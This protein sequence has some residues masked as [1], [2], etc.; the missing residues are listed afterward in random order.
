MPLGYPQAASRFGDGLV[1][2]TIYQNVALGQNLSK[3]KRCLGEV[4]KLS[5]PQATLH[6]FKASVAKRYKRTKETILTELLRGPSLIVDETEAQLSKEKAYV[7]VFAGVSGAYYEYRD[8]RNGQFLT[9]RLSG[10]SGVLVSDFFTAYDSIEC[11][12]Q[13]CLIHLIR[14]M[15]EDMKANPFDEELK[16][17]VQSFAS[18]TRPIMETVDKYGLTKSCLQKHKSAAMGFVEKVVANS[19]SS[20][21]AAKY[22]NRIKKYGQRLFTF[23]D[24]DD[25]PWNNNN[26]EH[27]VKAFA[28][29]RRFADG[30]FTENS[31]TDYLVILS[32]FQTCEYQGLS[33]LEF[34]LSGKTIFPFPDRTGPVPHV[35][36][37]EP[38]S[39]Q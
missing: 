17:I 31:V 5:I 10:F 16:G 19:V 29:Y 34:L 25:V 21:A 24:Y 33:V 22:Q 13:K 14:E 6:R 9:E 28:R 38:F 11:P 30:R 36:N 39:I 32:V 23:L 8:S 26:A 4:F 3:V 7:W 37:P 2:W 20:E 27:A 18:V 1:N 35:V 15:N 12:Q